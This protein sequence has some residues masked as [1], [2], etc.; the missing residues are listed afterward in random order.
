MT[1]RYG[2]VFRARRRHLGLTQHELS[3]LSGVSARFIHDLEHDKPSVRL[4][5]VLAVAEALGLVLEAR[6]R[7]VGERDESAG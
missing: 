6:V 7:D 3:D 4:S 1:E 2:D 5:A